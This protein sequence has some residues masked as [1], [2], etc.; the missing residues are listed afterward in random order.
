MVPSLTSFTQF[1]L[2]EEVEFKTLEQVT[3]LKKD[4]IPIVSRTSLFAEA[5]AMVNGKRVLLCLPLSGSID[6]STAKCSSMLKQVCAN[7]LTEYRVL[8]GE[9]TL[10]DSLGRE[11]ACDLILHEIPEGEPLN[12]AITH[13]AT[14]R[15]LSALNLLKQEML[16][17]GFLHGNLKPSNLIYGD[18]D[19]LY[20]IRYHHAHFNSTNEMISA[21]FERIEAF[22]AE[23]PVVNEI[24]AYTPASE[25]DNRLPYDQ[26]FAMQDMMRRVRKGDL[27]GYLDEFDTEVIKPQFPYAEDFFEDFAIVQ[28]TE[29]KMGAIDH[30]GEWLINPIYD[31]IGFE[32]GVFEARIGEEW[33]KL[34]YL[35]KIIEQTDKI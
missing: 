3:I 21:E 28:T 16:N 5:Q 7:A 12:V 31:M 35:G 1:L 2:S 19:R 25:Y 18:D 14:N 32:D 17:I 11:T 6:S 15:I 33:I 8:L 4:G 13:I 29:G 10:L 22:I 27:Y 26:F 23:H 30:N 9:I 24:G 34:D 20:P